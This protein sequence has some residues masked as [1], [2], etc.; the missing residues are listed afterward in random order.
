M[1]CGS[2]WRAEGRAPALRGNHDGYSLN[3]GALRAAH[4]SFSPQRYGSSASVTELFSQTLFGPAEGTMTS[5]AIHET[6]AT[7]AKMSIMVRAFFITSFRRPSV[8]DPVV[9]L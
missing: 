9:A 1:C 6:P 5:L 4:F 2:C 8:L 3:V 7:P